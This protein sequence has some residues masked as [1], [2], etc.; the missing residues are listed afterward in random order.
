[1]VLYETR[2]Y[3]NSVF[4]RDLSYSFW[5][6]EDD[7]INLVDWEESRR[8]V[9]SGPTEIAGPIRLLDRLPNPDPG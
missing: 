5:N 2:F 1:M 4:K 6:I 9:M 3:T 8:N 7:F